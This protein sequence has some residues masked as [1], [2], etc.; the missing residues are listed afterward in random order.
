M[1]WGVVVM[2]PTAID[3]CGHHEFFPCE[4]DEPFWK[5]CVVGV[6]VIVV[7]VVKFVL[8]V[9]RLRWPT[10]RANETTPKQETERMSEETPTTTAC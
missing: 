9:G 1:F 2:L 6:V 10:T 4:E 3:G 8:E 5:K 7:V